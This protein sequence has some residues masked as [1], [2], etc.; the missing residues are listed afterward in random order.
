MIGC[1]LNLGKK[2]I[3]RAFV[4]IRDILLHVYDIVSVLVLLLFET[5]V[6]I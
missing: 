5:T 1:G 2:V 3:T 4:M 6:L